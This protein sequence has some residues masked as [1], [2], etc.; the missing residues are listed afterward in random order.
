M[1][2]DNLWG[3]FACPSR[4]DT[5]FNDVLISFQEECASEINWQEIVYNEWREHKMKRSEKKQKKTIQS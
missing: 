5:G 4:E 1:V 2:S 3:S